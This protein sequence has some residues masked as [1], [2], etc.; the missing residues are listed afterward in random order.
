MTLRVAQIS[1]PHL[2]ADPSEELLGY[3]TDRSL[4]AVMQ[5]VVEERPALLLLTGDLAHDGSEAAYR[6]LAGILDRTG[7]EAACLPGNHDDGAT[8]ERALTGPRILRERDFARG[9]W[10]FI[11]LDSHVPGQ[12]V[13]ELAPSELTFLDQTLQRAAACGEHALV[14][15]HHQPAS[16]GS[17]WLDAIGL[18][19]ADSLL[20]VLDQHSALR[21]VLFGHVHQEQQ[22][23]RGEVAYY[24]CPSTCTQFVPRRPTVEVDALPPGFRVLELRPDGR[25]KTH[26]ERATMPP[27]ATA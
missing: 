22:F 14:A 25:L 5:R 20:D 8:V 9:G 27:D 3:F 17:E 26:V 18:R 23:Q 2:L 24:S 12:S 15:L 6:R 10:R 16:V 19:S 4:R 1:D 11:L 13:G 7:I 21:V